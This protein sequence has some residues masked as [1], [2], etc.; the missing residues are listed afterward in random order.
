MPILADGDGCRILS[1]LGVFYKVG[2]LKEKQNVLKTLELFSTDVISM[3]VYLLFMQIQKKKL[4]ILLTNY[5]S[6]HVL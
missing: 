6:D 2:I 5:K 1:R 3:I 4:L